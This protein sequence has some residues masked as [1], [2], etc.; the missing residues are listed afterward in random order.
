M[1]K[2]EVVA[3]SA[4]GYIQVTQTYA[5]GTYTFNADDMIALFGRLAS[6]LAGTWNN[7]TAKVTV[8]YD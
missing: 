7:G 5:P 8:E 4:A 1:I 3:I 2:E 6:G